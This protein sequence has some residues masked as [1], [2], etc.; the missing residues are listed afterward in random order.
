[1]I[2]SKIVKL[3][4]S[5]FITLG[6]MLF[7]NSFNDVS[8]VVADELVETPSVSWDNI[9][10]AGYGPHEINGIPQQGYCV[11]FQYADYR[12]YSEAFQNQV[13]SATI[14]NI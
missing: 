2:K 3:V 4:L 1:M 12:F 9:D 6:V 8:K 14:P 7:S 5:S 10:Y 11:L 13:L